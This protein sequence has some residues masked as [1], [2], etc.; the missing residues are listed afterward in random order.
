MEDVRT[1]LKAYVTEGE[2]P[3]GL[4]GEAVLAAARRARRQHLVTG[5]AAVC[6]V[7]LALALAVVV[8]PH[9]AEVASPPCP[10]ATDTRAALVERLSCLVGRAVRAMLP[11]EAQI[12]RLTIPGETPP[13]DPFHL[14]AD[15]AGDAPG[16]ALFH[17]GVRVTDARGTGSVYVLILPG[18][19]GGPKCGDPDQIG[20]RTETTPRG[21]LWLSTLRSGD[22]VTNRVG[23]AAPNAHVQFWSDNSGV[24]PRTGVRLPKQRPEPTLTLDQVRQLT[25]TPG[26]DL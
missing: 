11:P 24:L 18:G 25:L 5:A 17:L 20:C 22:V 1:V 23:L 9:R 10:G 2:P 13:A 16:E 14:I 26:L 3:I 7:V 6:V 15:P 12:S 4:S 19:G 8:L 21:L